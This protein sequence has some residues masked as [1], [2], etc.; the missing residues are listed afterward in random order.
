MTDSVSPLRERGA[1]AEAIPGFQPRPEQQAL[2]EA[3]SE[4]LAGGEVLVAEAGTGTGKT[5][6]YL[7]PALLSRRKVIISTGTKTLQDQLFRRDLP[8]VREA[9]KLPLRTALLKGRGNYLCIYRTE[10]AAQEGRFESREASALFQKIQRWSHLTRSGDLGEAPVG[11]LEGLM[12]GR[13]SSTADNCLGQECPHYSD[14]HLME[15]RRR[16]QEADVV[17]VNHHLLLADWAIREGGFGEVL[18]QADAY[19]L[20]EAHQLPETAQQF[21]GLSVSSRQ[22]HDLLRDARMEYYREAGDAPGMLEALDRLERGLLDLR[23]SLG[24]EGRR[25]AW[26]EL[27]EDQ[28]VTEAV[29][30][31]DDRLRAL[32]QV[33]EPLA[34]R[35][36]GLESCHRR[37][38]AAYQAWSKFL[39]PEAANAVRWYETYSQSFILRL[40]PLEVAG[41]FRGHMARQQAAWVFT[42]A[43]LSV[44]EG[45][46][47]FSRQLGL[48]EP[49]TL[50]LD[51]PFDYRRNAVL[52]C[53]RDLPEPNHPAY[54]Q[55][56]LQ[57]A[58]PVLQAS[59]GRAFMLF[60][61][62]RALREAAEW[63]RP[64]V[65]YPLLV[66]GDAGQNQLL[67]QFRE[68]GNAVLLGTASFWE[69]VDVRGEA[70]S[71]VIIDRLPF[72][73]PNDPVTQAKIEALKSAGQ[74]P[75][76]AF[77]LPHAVITLRQGVGRLIRDTEDR[78]VLMIGDPRLIN[79]SY[80]KVFLNSLPRMARTRDGDKVVGF[81]RSLRAGSDSAA[82]DESADAG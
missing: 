15:A 27:Q 74:S 6:A 65:D 33:L 45:F 4:A 14:C 25:A 60:T 46:E 73:A 53:P 49:R 9:L 11:A 16:A 75:F 38:E 50:K 72:A 68:A 44:A 13:V 37:A 78:G 29:E 32:V 22:M 42:S 1:L 41:Q 30:Q 66:Q 59:E 34:E 51:S 52:Y 47:H 55:A 63:L 28:T 61:S 76:G 31:L 12:H 58:L 80:G 48:E 43:T 24:T 40:T 62:H 69:G 23:L 10:M 3:V 56:F 71:C 57:A 26:A 81:L 19:V 2:A 7:V 35:G 54:Q 82:A 20:D 39:Q 79:R 18:P 5:F 17:V 8:L 36:K 77:Q 67:E 21:F 64:R 70:L